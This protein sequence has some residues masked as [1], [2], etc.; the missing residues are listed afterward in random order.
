MNGDLYTLDADFNPQPCADLATWA[1]W[2]ETAHRTLAKDR[3][4]RPGA[5]DVEVSTV[6][7]GIDHG[8]GAPRLWE[9]MIFGGP[10]DGQCWRYATRAEA[11]DGHRLACRRAF[12]N[13]A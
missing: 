5:P 11:L 9:T 7:L 3:D 10:L 4:E 13:G 6:F 8:V 2:F 12:T 1:R